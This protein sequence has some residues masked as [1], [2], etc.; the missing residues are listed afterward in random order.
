MFY[1]GWPPS[2]K[3][4]TTS[5]FFCQGFSQRKVLN[6]AKSSPRKVKVSFS[7]ALGSQPKVY[8]FSEPPHCQLPPPSALELVQCPVNVLMGG[9]WVAVDGGEGGTGHNG[10]WWILKYGDGM[11]EMCGNVLLLKLF[12]HFKLNITSHY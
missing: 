9:W 11:Q 6:M 2:T 12:S 10:P 4:K 1:K 7:F 8:H 5:P 3:L